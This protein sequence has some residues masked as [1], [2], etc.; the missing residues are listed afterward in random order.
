MV[1]LPALGALTH[2]ADGGPAAGAFNAEPGP[3]WAGV[4]PDV[5]GYFKTFTRPVVTSDKKP[6]AYK[7]MVKYDWSGGALKMLEVT[8]ARDPAFKQKYAAEALRKEKR[9]PKEV[10]VGKRTAWLWDLEKEA[11]GQPEALYGRLVVPLSEDKAL[12][13]D[14]RGQGPWEPLTDIAK[15]F[16]LDK[17]EQALES[18]PKVK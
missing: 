2:W 8:L 9:P 5:T 10:K 4:F 14:A 7:Q 3:G 16:N 12:I 18:P 15:H 11:Q 17:A 6:F 1:A 13:F